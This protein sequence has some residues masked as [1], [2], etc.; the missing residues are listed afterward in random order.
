MRQQENTLPGTAAS[1]GRPKR[2]RA[3]LRRARRRISE[4][5]YRWLRIPLGSLLVLAGLLGFLPILGF[6]MIPLGLSLLAVDFPV[7][8]PILRRFREWLRRL[9]GRERAD[10]R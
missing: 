1:N 5:R 10:S 7:L 3:V 4:P 2:L 6:W 9:L 8:R